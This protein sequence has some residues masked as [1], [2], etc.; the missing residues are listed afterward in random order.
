[1][2]VSA[3]AMARIYRSLARK[4]AREVAAGLRRAVS[5]GTAQAARVE[6]IG[7]AGKTGTSRDGA[8]FGGYAPAGKPA[9]AVAVFLPG[10]R[11]PRDAAPAAAE[12]FRWARRSG[13]L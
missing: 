11:G 3:Y 2:A 13:W 4:S 6:G 12:L 9:V 5:E 7:I 1:M 8:W 10:G